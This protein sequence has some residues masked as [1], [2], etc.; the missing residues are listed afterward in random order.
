MLQYRQLILSL[1][2]IPLLAIADNEPIK[3]RLAHANRY[4]STVDITQYLVSEK[5]DGVRGYWDGHKLYTRQGNRI[6]TPHWF[7]K[8]WPIRKLD[9][10]LWINRNRFEEVSAIVRRKHPQDQEWRTIR[11]MLFDLHPTGTEPN[12]TFEQRV[13]ELQGM[14]KQVNNPHL[15][16]IP[17][18]QLHNPKELHTKLDQLINRG[19]EGLM[20]HRRNAPYRAGRSDAILKLKPQWDAEAKVVGHIPGKGKYKGKLGALLVEATSEQP[21]Q[22]TRFRVG[23]GFSDAERANPPPVGSIITYRFQGYT[24]HGLPR[25]PVFLR[26]RE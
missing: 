11:F 23:T 7:T 12:T 4:T 22:G 18:H 6:N 17:Q 24:K 13:T 26:V 25:F 10:E 21:L 5:L 19:A 20:L 16:I 1:C 15:A 14:V 3:P 9:G 8:N 2:L